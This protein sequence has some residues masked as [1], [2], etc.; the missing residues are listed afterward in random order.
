MSWK[1]TGYRINIDRL[2]IDDKQDASCISSVCIHE[3]ISKNQFKRIEK[4]LKEN[5]ND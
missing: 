4:I 2:S 3:V 5:E 1:T